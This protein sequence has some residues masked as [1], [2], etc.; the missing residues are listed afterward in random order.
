M[1]L[2]TSI[3]WEHMYE[4]AMI[5]AVVR[6]SES[7]AACLWGRSFHFVYV[8][9]KIVLDSSAPSLLLLLPCILDQNIH[10]EYA[11]DDISGMSADD[12][13]F[14][15]L[16]IPLIPLITLYRYHILVVTCTTF[17]L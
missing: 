10:C 3:S 15:L 8:E 5:D 12:P 13:R 11:C 17:L 14:G 7:Q 16:S 6:G 9:A 4:I 2:N 1:T